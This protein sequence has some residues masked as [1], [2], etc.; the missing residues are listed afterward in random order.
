VSVPL[1]DLR[2]G[3]PGAN[4]MTWLGLVLFLAATGRG[5]RR[6]E[7][8]PMLRQ[9]LEFS[10]RVARDVGR[11]ERELPRRERHHWRLVDV[12]NVAQLISETRDGVQEGRE[13]G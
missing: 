1:Y 6:R 2:N 3:I 4:P 5:A 7:R 9:R 12:P 10:D 13:I 11:E 8:V